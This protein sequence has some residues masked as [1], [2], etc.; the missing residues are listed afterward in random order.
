MPANKKPVPAPA[1]GLLLPNLC[2]Y[3][4]LFVLLIATQLLVV[5][6]VVFRH[7]FY[8]DW[9]YFGQ[10]TLYM[11][12]QAMLSA[13]VLCRLR[14]FLSHISKYL[15]V[16]LAYAG[17]LLVAL[18][19]G[20]L[21]EW[22]LTRL[23]HHFSLEFVLRNV[24]LSAIVAGIALRYLYV[25]QQSLEREKAVLQASLAALQ[26]RIRPHFLFNTMNSIASLISIA[27]DKAEKMVEDLC[28]LLRA[29]LREDQLETTV[30]E[31]WHLC[32]CYL[33]IEQQRL[34]DRL[35]WRS[36]FTGL[37]ADKVPIPAL[38]LQPLVENAIYHGIQPHSAPGMIVVRGWQQ[39]N[40]VHI[41]ICNSK[42]VANDSG[43][44][45]SGNRMAV[46]NIRLRM[47]RLYGE[48][49]SLSLTDQ[50]ERFVVHL[51]YQTTAAGQA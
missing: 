50:G 2:E 30:A 34:G 1:T 32:Q 19:L 48:S 40:T 3:Q 9:A 42:A 16:T 22:Q 38:S 33:A 36:D 28:E 46:E 13:I 47:Q 44:R 5:A 6:F 39:G 43:E 29:S 37:Q 12:W 41:E 51:Q 11:Q 26:A 49:A 25:Q 4:S 35:G 18:L 45:H 14:D 15:A 21:V 10:V 7:G 27:P 20:L 23:G 24:L 17:L 31:E 8:F